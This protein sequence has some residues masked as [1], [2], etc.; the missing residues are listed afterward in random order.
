MI[1]N[2]EVKRTFKIVL[3]SYNTNSYTG[4]QFNASYYIDLPKIINDESAFDKSYKV[5]CNFQTIA[6]T[7]NNSEI[8]LSSLYALSLNFNGIGGL[9]VYQYDQSKNFDFNLPVINLFDTAV[10]PNAQSHTLLR[11]NEM[12]QNPIF[13]QNIRN[14]TYINLQVYKYN[15]STPAIFN[16]NTPDASKYLCILTFVEC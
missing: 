1:S 5:Y 12:D 13:L 9:Q 16:P 2:K 6:N 10:A 11:L 3:D 14:M 7:A 15:S 4:T 8:G